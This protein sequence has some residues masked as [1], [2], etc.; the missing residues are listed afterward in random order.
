[1]TVEQVEGGATRGERSEHPEERE[2]GVEFEPSVPAPSEASFFDREALPRPRA[3]T[4]ERAPSSVAPS[5]ETRPTL[6]LV[7]RPLRALA[8]LVTSM[9]LIGRGLVPAMHGWRV[10]MS[11]FIDLA[12][13]AVE[14][15]AQLCA[16]LSIVA[17]GALL[18]QLMRTRV[19]IAL[20]LGAM[21]STLI[22]IT[23]CLA[24][25]G[26]L[27][28]PVILHV[29]L[30]GAAILTATLCATDLV[31]R[32]PL[33]GATILATVLASLLRGIGSYVAEAASIER[34]NVETMQAAFDFAH[35]MSTA[36]LVMSMI[37]AI[38]AVAAFARLERVRAAPF[39]AG[40]LAL[41]VGVGL[42]VRGLPG[43]N[44]ASITVL[45]RR[46]GQQLVTLPAPL[47][48]PFFAA[49]GV[50]L[51][52]VLSIAIAAGMRPRHRALGP[53]LG[54]VLLAGSSAEVPLFG[55]A[56]VLGSLGMLIDRRD[57]EGVFAA[58]EQGQR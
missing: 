38:T 21:V 40:A 41:A 23:L 8:I 51:L 50:T 55:L 48:S 43:E 25:L 15:A 57:S 1:M 45:L 10:G 14:V 58:L 16:M 28:L 42:A 53:A 24:A 29:G 5:S 54:L 27:R 22:T 2:A 13:L 56:L 49:F 37:A 46:L 30:G 36:A 52:T 35:K 39:V 7:L 33:A 19:S 31:R 47:G 3:S 6:L 18:V 4:P 20:R 26:L 34:R 9:T 44:D 11:R 32:A 17:A 12:D